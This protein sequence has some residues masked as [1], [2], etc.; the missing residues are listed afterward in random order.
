MKL[1]DLWSRTEECILGFELVAETACVTEDEYIAQFLNPL[2]STGRVGREEIAFIGETARGVLRYRAFLDATISGYCAALKK[3]KQNAT[4][5]AMLYYLVFYRF[6]ELGGEVFRRIISHSLS[7]NRVAEM[8]ELCLN[9]AALREH[10]VPRWQ[11]VFDDAYVE[12][13]VMG[14]LRRITLELTEVAQYFRQKASGTTDHFAADVSSSSGPNNTA[15]LTRRDVA[16]FSFL[17]R[18]PKRNKPA[19]P[20]YEIRMLEALG[21]K[22]EFPKITTKCSDAEK[23]AIELTKKGI[24]GASTLD[25]TT[26]E[27]NRARERAIPSRSFSGTARPLQ[28]PQLVRDDELRHKVLMRPHTTT[29]DPAAVRH[30]LNR[31][32]GNVKVTMTDTALRREHEVFKRRTDEEEK[33]R[34]RKELELRDESEFVAWKTR[35]D[36]EEEADRL[37]RVAERKAEL[38]ATDAAAR[39]T[40]Q[41]QQDRNLRLTRA[42]KI[43]L[44]KWRDE[45][46]SDQTHM[47]EQKHR[48]AEAIRNEL[49]QGA[50]RAA[51]TVAVKN[52]TA[53]TE[54]R[55]ESHQ[56]EYTLALT[57]E[58]EKQRKQQL[59]DEIKAAHAEF[60]ER[61]KVLHESLAARTANTTANGKLESMTIAEL[62]QKMQEVR[63]AQKTW[64]DDQRRKIQEGKEAAERDAAARSEFV[65]QHREK[66]R[67]EKELDRDKRRETA[68]EREAEQK[69][70][71][72]QLAVELQK[73][74]EVT[75]KDK[76][77]AAADRVRQERQR[78]VAAQ[79][80]AAD[81]GQMEVA[82]WAEM[83]RGKQNALVAVQNSSLV[84]RK[85]SSALKTAQKSLT[86]TN[87]TRREETLRDALAAS[88]TAF[89]TK[90][91]RARRETDED[92]AIRFAATKKMME[93]AKTLRQLT[94]SSGM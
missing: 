56:R 60:V 90:K 8:L 36:A 70:R 26:R 94:L 19:L 16:P 84:S 69:R 21:Q 50:E 4:S 73:K 78:K 65:R 62:R 35:L 72:E 42:D 61:Q 10:V 49:A 1:C 18:A 88:E 29:Q 38:I 51:V 20:P 44:T 80:L 68:S 34:L 48:R 79:L 86:E 46:Q 57:L 31:I 71:D 54:V 59:I 52:K 6:E 39:A 13:Q 43:E 77:T 55:D 76:A 32:Q 85:A 82:K 66:Q 22:E 2:E 7:Y 92:E 11:A 15:S 3:N 87:L 9:E 53:A 33:A 23:R 81:A 67:A 58:L 91:S 30:K 41:R 14:T 83:E 28:L 12:K 5:I 27:E 75:R 45:F 89:Q 37:K 24:R 47:Q 74:L 64:E 40:R 25:P 63:A 93:Q 17:N